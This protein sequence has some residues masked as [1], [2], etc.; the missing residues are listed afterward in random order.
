MWVTPGGVVTFRMGR[1]VR[2]CV[3]VSDQ[4]H[5]VVLQDRGVTSYGCIAEES[6]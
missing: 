4:G 1:V 5:T 2:P 6:A 3:P